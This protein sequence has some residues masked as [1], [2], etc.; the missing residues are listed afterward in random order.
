MKHEIVLFG[1]ASIPNHHKRRSIH[2]TLNGLLY[3]GVRV[4]I[5]TTTV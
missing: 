3:C 2:T 1:M 4:L 5:T